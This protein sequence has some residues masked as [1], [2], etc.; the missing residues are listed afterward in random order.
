MGEQGLSVTKAPSVQLD[1]IRTASVTIR[2][3]DPSDDGWPGKEGGKGGNGG[4]TG[5]KV[6]ARSSY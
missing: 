4:V 2:K 5:G 6:K 1:L 3:R